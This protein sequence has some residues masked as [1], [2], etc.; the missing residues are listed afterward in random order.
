MCEQATQKQTSNEI[1]I[2]LGA[3]LSFSMVEILHSQSKGN[4]ELHLT[5]TLHFTVIRDKRRLFLLWDAGMG[6]SYLHLVD[7]HDHPS[8]LQ[9][10]ASHLQTWL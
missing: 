4:C 5:W 8:G 7:T 2:G 6:V 10:S 9:A 3:I 1:F